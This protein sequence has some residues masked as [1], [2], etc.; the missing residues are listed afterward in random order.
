MTVLA[1]Y[2]FGAGLLTV[3]EAKKQFDSYAKLLVGSGDG[4]GVA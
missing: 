1:E 2:T 4:A 3:L